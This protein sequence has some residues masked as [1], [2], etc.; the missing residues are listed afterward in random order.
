MHRATRPVPSPQPKH[1]RM[2]MI[3]MCLDVLQREDVNIS[4]INVFQKEKRVD[5][6]LLLYLA[7]VSRTGMSKLKAALTVNIFFFLTA[8]EAASVG[9]RDRGA[10]SWT[11]PRCF[12]GGFSICGQDTSGRRGERFGLFITGILGRGL[13][14]VRVSGLTRCDL[15]RSIAS[16]FFDTA[17]VVLMDL[18]DDI[19]RVD[20][21]VNTASSGVGH[22]LIHRRVKLHFSWTIYATVLRSN[23]LYLVMCFLLKEVQQHAL[24][25]T[26]H[27]VRLRYMAEMSIQCRSIAFYPYDYHPSK[28]C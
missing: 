17:T 15:Y 26:L 18:T 25:K 12:A 8:G 11:R 14:Q 27:A 23:I 22:T 7:V 4:V 9:E 24:N 21:T 5:S 13:W 28:M 10:G 3:K 20:F 2:K 19:I 6:I 16:D 1:V